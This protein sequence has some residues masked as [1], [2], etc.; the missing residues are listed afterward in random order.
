MTQEDFNMMIEAFR[1]A[2]PVY[3]Q[4]LTKKLADL[5]NGYQATAEEVAE[6]N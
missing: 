4:H 5:V 1:F 6:G 3:A 2:V